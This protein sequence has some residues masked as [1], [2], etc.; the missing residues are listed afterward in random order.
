M[1]V[2]LSEQISGIIS[3]V[4][5]YNTLYTVTLRSN[6]S[7][8]LVQLQLMF[9]TILVSIEQSR[10]VHFEP[11]CVRIACFEDFIWGYFW[12]DISGGTWHFDQI[13]KKRL[14]DSG[15]PKFWLAVWCVAWGNFK[16][17]QSKC[18]C[19]FNSS[20]PSSSSTTCVV[21]CLVSISPQ[22]SWP[23][24]VVPTPG[25]CPFTCLHVCRGVR[26]RHANAIILPLPGWFPST[27]GW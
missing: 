8:R 25:Q 22:V 17:K 16:L 3:S 4:C 24:P 12:S 13:D 11:L 14:L 10:W 5:L 26:R 27:V 18:K 19:Y 6:K 15:V 23:P 7:P 1:T 2:W 21:Q 20:L 9:V